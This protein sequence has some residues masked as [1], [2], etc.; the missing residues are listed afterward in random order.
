MNTKF[1][2]EVKSE[3]SQPK[4]QGVK[5]GGDPQNFDAAFVAQALLTRSGGGGSKGYHLEFVFGDIEE[6]RALCEVLAI[7]DVF[8][9]MIVRRSVWVVYI[10]NSDCICNLL[11]LVGASKSLLKLHDEIALRD[12][13]NV[14]NRRANC[15]TANI[16]KQVTAASTQIEIIERLQQEGKL[17]LL[18]DRLRETARARI[19]NPDATYEELAHLLKI[20]KSGIV[21]RLKEITEK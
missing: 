2:E 13:R 7:Y 14:S 20:S 12:L 15:D 9:K 10:K 1:W 4:N 6:G 21:H 16:S 3:I 8:A 17:E 5:D 18:D 19:E 11:A